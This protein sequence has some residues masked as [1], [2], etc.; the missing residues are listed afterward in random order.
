MG[1]ETQIAS[2]AFNFM[3]AQQQR[4][5]YEMEAQL[6]EEQ[7]DME[8]IKTSQQISQVN[9]KLRMQLASLDSSMSAQGIALGTSASTTALEND[10]IKLASNDISSIKLMGLSNRRKYGLSAASSRAKAQSVTLGSFAKAAAQG[11]EISQG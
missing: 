1:V 6:Y 8:A 2:L 4:S 5:A 10:E 7:K 9:R 11:Y 3:A